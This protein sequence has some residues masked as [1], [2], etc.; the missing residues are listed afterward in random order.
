MW[1]AVFLFSLIV[2]LFIP[3][4]GLAYQVHDQ[5]TFSTLPSGK[6]LY[7]DISQNMEKGDI[8]AAVKDFET[9]SLLFWITEP[10]VASGEFCSPKY[11]KRC[12]ERVK[13]LKK[14]IDDTFERCFSS[15]ESL[16]T[17]YSDYQTE[18]TNLIQSN[19]VDP[20]SIKITFSGEPEKTY[21]ATHTQKEVK[22]KFGWKFSGKYNAKN[23]MGGYTG[24]SPFTCY[25]ADGKVMECYFPESDLYLTYSE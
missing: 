18:A 25:I 2:T 9:E 17:H 19:L 16:F 5:K 22:V 21:F 11:Q 3:T 10:L 8:S 1:K 7:G 24:F 13:G 20:D 12:I 6:G 15:N 23:Q 14:N 4:R